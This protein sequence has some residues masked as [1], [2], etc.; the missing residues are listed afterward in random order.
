MTWHKSA[1]EGVIE[2]TLA[3]ASFDMFLFS[4]II[5]DRTVHVVGIKTLPYLLKRIRK[6]A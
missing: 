2:K 5:S 4:I 1:S 6:E 3:W